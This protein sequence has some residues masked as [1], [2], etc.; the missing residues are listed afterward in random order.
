MIITKNNETT[1]SSRHIIKV[2]NIQ[3]PHKEKKYARVLKYKVNIS[4]APNKD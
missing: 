2:S 4:Y 1:S 3:E